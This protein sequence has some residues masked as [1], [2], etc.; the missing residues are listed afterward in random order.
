MKTEFEGNVQS[1][2]VTGGL[3]VSYSDVETGRKVVQEVGTLR[4]VK[5]TLEWE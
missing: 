5:V 2:N 1:L 3:V 4:H